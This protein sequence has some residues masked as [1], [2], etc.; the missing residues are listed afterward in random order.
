M[1]DLGHGRYPYSAPKF[2]PARIYVATG[3]YLL[4]MTVVTLINNVNPHLSGLIFMGACVS[5]ILAAISHISFYNVAESK[6]SDL[7]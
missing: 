2:M 4:C 3:L 1:H 5:F 6:D 7:E